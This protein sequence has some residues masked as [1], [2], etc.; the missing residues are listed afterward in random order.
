MPMTKTM[1][2]DDASLKEE[3]N[4]NETTNCVLSLTQS[5]NIASTSETT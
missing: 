3:T 4:L 2:N 1:L 5:Y